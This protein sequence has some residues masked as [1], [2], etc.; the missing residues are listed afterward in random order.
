MGARIRSL[1]ARVR[2]LPPGRQD[3][4]LALAFF[5][6]GNVEFSLVDAPARDVLLARLVLCMTCAGVALRRR[7]PILGAT[8]MIATFLVF[9]LPGLA[10]IEQATGGPFLTLFLAVYSVSANL[11]GRRLA[12]ASIWVVVLIVAAIVVSP[13]YEGVTDLIWGSLIGFGAPWGLGRL[14]HQRTRLARAMREQARDSQEERAAQAARAVDEER[15]RIAAELHDIVAAALATMVDRA[16]AAQRLVDEDP[17]GA[18]R[19]FA[20]VENAGRDALAEIRGV[21]GVLRRDDEELAL[22]PQPT[23]AHLPSLLRRMQAAGLRADLHIEGSE[24]PLPAGTD[25]TAY[26]VVQEALTAALEEGSAGAAEVVVRYGSGALEVKVVD[27]A[28]GRRGLAGV[29]ERVALYGG[30]LQAGPLR[31][32]GHAVRA[33]LPAGDGA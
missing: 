22:S 14:I 17:D 28:G 13:T 12:L 31:S 7:M 23:L 20:E 29:R 1:A 6:E 9:D 19:S 24:R 21:L 5:V 4:L 3:A 32:G 10:E 16:D 27:D 18:A 26:R 8:L 25:L 11:D 30:E 33:R 2:D 15:A